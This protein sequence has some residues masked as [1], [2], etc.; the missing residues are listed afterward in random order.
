MTY[1]EFIPHS[2]LCLATPNV[3][4]RRGLVRWMVRGESK[5]P[6]DN[7]WR[8]MSHIDTEEYLHTDGCWRIVTFNDV[9]NIEPALIGIYDFK[10]GSDLQIVRDE[11]GINIYDTPTGRMI[12]RENYYV[13]PQ[14][15]VPPESG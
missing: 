9:C 10:V 6:A 15:R 5:A 7:G 1:H 2:G 3:M 13:P 8:I 12:P 11:R 14:W 4:E